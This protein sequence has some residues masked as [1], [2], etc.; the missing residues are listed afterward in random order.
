MMKTDRFLNIYGWVLIV[1]FVGC[2][3]TLYVSTIESSSAFIGYFGAAITLWYFVTGIGILKRKVWGYYLLKSFLYLLLLSFPIGTFISYKSLKYMK[4]N[5]IRKEF[6][7][8]AP[9]DRR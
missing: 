5:S 9:A 2:L 3:Y 1:C 4:K 7:T 8:A 6:S